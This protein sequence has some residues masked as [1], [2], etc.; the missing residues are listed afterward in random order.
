MW[1]IGLAITGLVL[2]V[3]ATACDAGASGSVSTKLKVEMSEF[4]FAPSS[5]M[6]PAGEEITLELKNSGSIKHDFIILKEGITVNGRFDSEKRQDDIYFH[7]ALDSDKT[8]T[9]TFTAPTGEG[10]YQVIC[11]IAGHFQAGMTGKLTVVAEK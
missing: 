3:M 4:S 9:F 5:F 10:E 8:D 1:K 6:V 11:G 2:A 7:A